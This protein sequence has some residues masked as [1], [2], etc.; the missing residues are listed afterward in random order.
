[1]SEEERQRW[2]RLNPKGTQAAPKKKWRFLQKY[3]HR[4]AFFQVGASGTR[5]RPRHA[6]LLDDPKTNPLGGSHG[7]HSELPCPQE[8]EF[9]CWR[10]QRQPSC[11]VQCSPL[12]T[13]P[14]DVQTEADTG[15]GEDVGVATTITQRDFSA[16]TGE[17]KMDKAM[18][19]QIM[20]VG[21]RC[22]VCRVCRAM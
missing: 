11:W 10:R 20:Q 17:D 2:L 4:G 18:L 15:E 8:G 22:S 7:A 6:V 3:W 1:M 14:A 12:P 13:P 16:P 9:P 5:E 21:G 19:P